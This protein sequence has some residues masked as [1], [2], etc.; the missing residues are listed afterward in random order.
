[1]EKTTLSVPVQDGNGVAD[2]DT[3]VRID[4]FYVENDG[5]YFIP[6][7]VADTLKKD[8]PNKACVAHKP[9]AEWKEMRPENFVFSLYPNDLIRVTHRKGIN[10]AI[11][12]KDSTL[13]PVKVEREVFLY[14]NGA[15]ISSGA[16]AGVTHD[17]TY[18]ASIGIKT[19][20]RM[21]KFVVDV[22]GTYHAV[23]KV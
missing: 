7:Y 12:N 1:M 15:N 18:R 13:P 11:Q 20:E 23:G 14:Y 2:H 6:I 22:L 5:Y 3:M 9:Y 17:N 10:L 4:V 21:D 8:L 19:L 16:V